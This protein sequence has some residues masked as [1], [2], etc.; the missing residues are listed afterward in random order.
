[1][2]LSLGSI[3]NSI[4]YSDG[5]IVDIVDTIFEE[6]DTSL[7]KINKYSNQLGGNKQEHNKN[8]DEDENSTINISEIFSH[9]FDYSD[10]L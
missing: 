4:E 10:L 7:L 1:M 5:N 3:D 2:S 6:L 9:P 8:K